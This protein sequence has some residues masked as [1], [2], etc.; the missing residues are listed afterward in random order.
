ME[1]ELQDFIEICN[2][3]N[4]SDVTLISFGDAIKQILINTGG[5]QRGLIKQIIV[6]FQRKKLIFDEIVSPY[7]EIATRKDIIKNERFVFEETQDLVLRLKQNM[8][9]LSLNTIYDLSD[10]LCSEIW[11][12]INDY[13][14][15]KG[16][17]LNTEYIFDLLNQVFIEGLEASIQDDAF[18]RL[19][20]I[21][22]RSYYYKLIIKYR[23][24]SLKEKISLTAR[25]LYRVKRLSG[26]PFLYIGS[27][28]GECDSKGHLGNNNFYIDLRTKKYSAIVNLSIVKIKLEEDFV[29]F[30]LNKFFQLMLDY[31]IISQ[32]VYNDLIYGTNDPL[33]LS[34]S[35]L[36]LSLNIINKL[37]TDG[38]L[39]NLSIDEFGNLAYNEQFLKYK[40]DSD[41]FFRFAL[42]K[43]L[44]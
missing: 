22:S 33:I 5:I 23:K 1:K 30:T 42:N 20:N 21:K 15:H 39:N 12:R 7:Y 11:S 13:K 44:P 4:Q 32:Q 43:F 41:D 40:E 38:Q 25:Y 29:G 18:R 28:Y 17:L 14:E 36:G 19:V 24:L 37:R 31:E 16:I 6:Y 26:E 35:K 2:I 34:L 27:S 8:L 9:K 3:T 10:S